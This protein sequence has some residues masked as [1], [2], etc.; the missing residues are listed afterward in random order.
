VGGAV[1]DVDVDGERVW[2]RHARGDFPD[3]ATL[4]ERLRG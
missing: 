1:F 4:I 2:S 3:D